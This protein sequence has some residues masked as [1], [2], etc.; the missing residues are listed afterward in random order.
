V[1]APGEFISAW[2]VPGSEMEQTA[3]AVEAIR[4]MPAAALKQLLQQNPQLAEGL[5]LPPEMLNLP[6][7]QLEKVLKPNLPPTYIPG[8]GLIAAPGTSFAAPLVAGVLATLEEE[9]DISP[10]ASMTILR[11]TATPMGETA[12]VE[13]KGFV[14]AKLALDVLRQAVEKANTE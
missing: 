14:D 3:Q 6:A 8:P 12:T 4:A 11:E 7:E 10:E 2:S 1:I 9:Y 5:G 13:G